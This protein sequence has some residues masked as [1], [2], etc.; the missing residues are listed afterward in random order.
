MKLLFGFS[1]V[2][3]I[4][5]WLDHF[6]SKGFE[7]D[8]AMS[9][10]GLLGTAINFKPDVL[11]ADYQLKGDLDTL[12]VYYELLSKPENHQVKLIL[13]SDLPENELR[14]M[15]KNI[16]QSAGILGIISPNKLEFEAVEELL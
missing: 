4:D 3:A 14:K 6:E 2:L 12:G 5:A 7:V 1:D 13:I 9:G 8:G 11:I 15:N 10:E 16:I